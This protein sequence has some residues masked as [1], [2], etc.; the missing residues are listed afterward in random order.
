MTRQLRDDCFLHDK[1]RLTH[2]EAINIL[3]SRIAPLTISAETVSVAE[4]TGRILADDISAPRAIPA[5]DNA[6]VDG[7]GFR[8]ADYDVTGGGQFPVV[9][10]IP[11]GHPL[12]QEILPGQAVRIFTGAALPKGLETIVMQEDTQVE[13]RGDSEWIIVPPGLKRGS[14]RRL[15]GEDY[16]GGEQL[17]RSGQRLRPQDT[18]A[19]A[20][21][22]FSEV[23]CRERLRV[24]SVSSGDEIVRAGEPFEH[25]KV[26]DANGPMLRG[27]IALTG[28]CTYDLG[29][30]NDDPR[31]VRQVLARAAARH[32]VVMTSGGASL[33]EEDHIVTALDDLGTRHLW[34]IAIKPGRP[35]TFGQIDDC[36]FVGLPGNPVAVFVCFL[37]YAWPLLMRLS[38][39]AWLEPTRFRVP[40]SFDI[41]SKKPD[42]R[43]FWRGTLR[44][45]ADGP[46]AVKFPRDGSGLISGLTAADGLIEV[47]ED[48]TELRAGEMVD[49]IPFTSFGMAANENVEPSMN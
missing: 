26:F 36:V 7:Y 29:V 35:M 18:A 14:N 25:G 33:G 3:K 24:A 39:T 38:G 11:A 12:R 13:T 34:Q 21:G 27:L 42:R 30:M 49:F 43:E 8:F 23:N 17:A 2:V 40:A 32:H 37:L 47:G 20:S 19:I 4:A 9:A 41:P 31:V 44:T 1:D 6:A 28:S 48:V 22:G 10:R 46:V 5:H 16:S 45:T 15:A